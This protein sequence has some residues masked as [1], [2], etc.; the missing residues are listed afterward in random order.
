M[1]FTGMYNQDDDSERRTISKRYVHNEEEEDEED[2]PVLIKPINNFS[3]ILAEDKDIDEP[4]EQQQITNVL[5][6]NQGLDA[7]P[8]PNKQEELSEATEM[9]DMFASTT[10]EC[11]EALNALKTD[12]WD[13]NAWQNLIEE[14]E[15]GHGGNLT[16]PDV[17]ERMLVHF[18][19][20]AKCWENYSE[21][22]IGQGDTTMAEEILKKAAPECWNLGVWNKYLNMLSTK[23]RELLSSKTSA[24]VYQKEKLNCENM[25]NIAVSCVGWAIDSYLLWKNYIDFVNSW[26]ENEAMEAARKITTV[27]KVFQKAL[28]IPIDQADNLWKEYETFERARNDTNMETLLQDTQRRFQHARSIL[29]E[30]R[31]YTH[32]IVFDRV[33]TPSCNSPSEIQQ[34]DLWNNWIR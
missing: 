27:R 13:N 24:E 33:A 18:P 9:P 26:P 1:E 15:K 10:S 8:F 11:Q 20:S 32:Q 6:L 30:R 4:L 16:I 7:Q 21:Y 29:R 31:R 14:V 34:L 23:F 22:Y 5:L 12:P 25:F 28:A 2:E 17:F 19:K 3:T